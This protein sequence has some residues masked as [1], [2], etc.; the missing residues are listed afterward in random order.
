MKER[1]SKIQPEIISK[2]RRSEVTN[3]IHKLNIIDDTFFHKVAE[4]TKACEEL[5]QILLE[6]KTIQLEENIPQYSLRNIGKR[7][8]ILDLLCKTLQGKYICMEVEKST[9]HHHLKRVRYNISNLDTR[10]AEKGIEFTQ[11]PDITY[12][13]LTRKDFF[14][15]SKTIHQIIRYDKETGEKSENGIHEI[16]INAELNDGSKRAKLMKYLIKTEGYPP[17]FPKISARV[18]QLKEEGEKE[19]C[20]LIENYAQK[21]TVE[22]FVDTIFEFLSPLGTIP[23]DL[24]Q[25]IKEQQ[26]LKLLK[27]WLQLAA[28]AD[29]IETFQMGLHI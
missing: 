17:D 6:D 4:D 25:K 18:H 20:E 22:S 14:A 24:S 5:L 8:V 27:H 16:Y 9:R 29:T 26:D 19:M 3:L 23:E 10:T 11:L 7:S 13:Y 15:S 2:Q 28:R 21:R 1:T 12:L